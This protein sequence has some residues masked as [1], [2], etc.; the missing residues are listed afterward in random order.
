MKGPALFRGLS[1]TT[2]FAAS[3]S[4]FAGVFPSSFASTF[5]GSGLQALPL[6][7][8]SSSSISSGISSVFLLLIDPVDSLKRSGRN[9]DVLNSSAFLKK[10]TIL[11]LVLALDFKD[12]G[13][14][15]TFCGVAFALVAIGRSVKQG[16]EVEDDVSGEG[17]RPLEGNACCSAGRSTFS[18]GVLNMRRRR[19]TYA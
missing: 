16:D 1:F 8:W 6:W 3:S 19:K 12:F 13:T 10:A 4:S 14:A 18:R 7:T 15:A 9:K 17:A 11:P 2:G 5:G